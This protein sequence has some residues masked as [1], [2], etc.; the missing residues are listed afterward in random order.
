MDE[1]EKLRWLVKV[2]HMN[3][4]EKIENR[5]FKYIPAFQKKHVKT[6]KNEPIWQ[7]QYHQR[8]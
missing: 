4:R 8:H 3:L 6:R 5:R 2:K 1:E 7:Q